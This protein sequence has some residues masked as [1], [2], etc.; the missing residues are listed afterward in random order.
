M[1]EENFVRKL[2]AL[3]PQSRDVAVGPGDDCAADKKARITA[4][5]TNSLPA[6]PF[7]G[8]PFLYNVP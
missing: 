3:F 1:N 8:Q 5:R 4:G 2:T 7:L 6:A